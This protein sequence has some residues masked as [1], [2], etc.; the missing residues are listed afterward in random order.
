MRT[1]LAVLAAAALAATARADEAIR[2]V[3]NQ[4]SLFIALAPV[5]L[6]E[7]ASDAQG[8]SFAGHAYGTRYL[9]GF[10]EART[11]TILGVADV[12]TDLEV[13]LGV[14]TLG[15]E[16]RS[17]DP[18]NA[19]GADVTV[20]VSYGEESVRLR[21][22]RSYESRGAMRLA[23]TPFL[24]LTQQAW[25]RD[26]PTAG[27]ASFYDFPGMQLG[28]LAQAGLPGRLVLGADAAVGRSLGTILFGGNYGNGIFA[29]VSTFS[30]K[31]DHCTSADWHQ[32]LEIRQAVLRYGV[33]GRTPGYYE[34]QR[35]S[36]LAI[37]LEFGTESS[38]F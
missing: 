9:F 20:P 21:V 15:Y 11:R 12:Y 19:P 18:G 13:S 4:E 33:S 36:E 2:A 37:M 38:I 25:L 29:K 8:A 35:G 17:L 31:L 5:H 28:A 24:G 7:T 1:R 23:V 27:N 3:N 16:G 14:A 32:R 10:D 26:Q 22:G 6:G 34:P 30:L